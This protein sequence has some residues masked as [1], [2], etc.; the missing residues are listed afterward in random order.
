MSVVESENQKCPH[1]YP[2]HIRSECPD[3]KNEANRTHPFAKEPVSSYIDPKFKSFGSEGNEVIRKNRIDNI[4]A[5]VE[6]YKNGRE[7]LDEL[8]EKYG[9]PIVDYSNVVGKNDTGQN[10]MYSISKTV[11]GQDFSQYL[12]EHS[13]NIPEG[14]QEKIN[15]HFIALVKYY[16]DKFVNG[17]KY[18][19]DSGFNAQY[20]V[21]KLDKDLSAPDEIYLVDIKPRIFE[22]KPLDFTANQELLFRISSLIGQIR[23]VEAKTGK[24]LS[25]PRALLKDFFTRLEETQMPEWFK[26]TANDLNEN[27]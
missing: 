7:L 19:Y 27:R 9:I 1:G 24:T 21:G 5:D 20:A 22:A 17:G 10:V 25:E 8:R 3:C 23:Q 16:T 26:K 15:L 4:D 11:R 14:I 18:L 13:G 12:Q 6:M 2:A